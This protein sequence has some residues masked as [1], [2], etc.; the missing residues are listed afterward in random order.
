MLCPGFSIASLCAVI[1]HRALI[2]RVGTS[3]QEM[4]SNSFDSLLVDQRFL[5]GCQVQV[6]YCNSK[7]SYIMPAWATE[8]L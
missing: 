6:D 3:V 8:A 7:C 1:F 5:E 4:D 2:F